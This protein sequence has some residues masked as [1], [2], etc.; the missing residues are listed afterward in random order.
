VLTLDELE[1]S[2]AKYECDEDLRSSM[3][4]DVLNAYGKQLVWQDKISLAIAIYSRAFAT[5]GRLS[6]RIRLAMLANGKLNTVIR[7]CE[8]KR[9]VGEQIF[10]CEIPNLP[11]LPGEYKINVGLDVA[12]QEVDYVEDATRLTVITSDF[13]GL[14]P[15]SRASQM[16]KNP[17]FAR[18]HGM[19][20]NHAKRQFFTGAP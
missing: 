10:P 1:S 17:V 2:L 16:Y 18:F 13:Y 6:T 11:L 7:Y 20:P 19:P 15:M 5:S 3:L 4:A 8:P 9:M 12:L 14:C